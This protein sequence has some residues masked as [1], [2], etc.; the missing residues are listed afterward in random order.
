MLHI[1]AK[2]HDLWI[3]YVLSFGVNEDTANDIVQEFYLKMSAFNGDIMIGEK[4]NFYF[5]YLVIRNMVFD[6]KKKEKKIK[7]VE[8]ST[9]RPDKWI[10]PQKIWADYVSEINSEPAEDDNAKSFFVT[11]WL[12][13]HNLKNIDLLNSENAKEIYEAC[14]FNEVMFE[15]KSIA[16]LSR[17]TTISYYSLYNT[18]KMIKKDIIDN[19]EAWDNTRKDI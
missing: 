16:Q 8:I 2:H 12:K 6:L 10:P 9:E 18:I 3:R 19:Y 15:N 4:I 17:E 1:L 7:L 14:I 11:K 5:V 13:K